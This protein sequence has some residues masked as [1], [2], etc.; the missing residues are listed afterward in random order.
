LQARPTRHPAGGSGPG[1]QRKKIGNCLG[2]QVHGSTFPDKIGISYFALLIP[3]CQ[4]VG[5]WEAGL[6]FLARPLVVSQEPDEPCIRLGI[7]T[8][9]N[10]SLFSLEPLAQTWL[11]CLIGYKRLALHSVL[12]CQECISSRARA[13]VNLRTL[14]LSNYKNCYIS[15]SGSEGSN[16]KNSKFSICF[17]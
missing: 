12:W 17:T 9:G 10:I 14:N 1:T 2:Y 15:P 3:A 13:G 5:R 16:A 7:D 8:F 4:T 6:D 11:P